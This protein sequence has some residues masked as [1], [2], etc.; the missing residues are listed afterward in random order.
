MD[1]VSPHDASTEAS[2]LTQVSTLARQFAR[3]LISASAADDLA[4][5][6]VVEC[7][8]RMRAGRW[9]VDVSLSA[10]VHALVRR[11]RADFLRQR[12][13][14]TSREAEHVR[15][16]TESTH[17]WMSPELTLEAQE[18]ERFHEQTLASLP[19]RCRQSYVMVR[20]QQAAY[21]VVATELGISRAAVCL[22]VVAAQR[23]FRE[24]LVERGF[25]TPTHSQ[26]GRRVSPT[27]SPLAP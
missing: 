14:R 9:R 6:V 15:E 24:V 17:A 2:L 26:N 25:A 23:H 8:T 1:T 20:E 21:Q 12:Q 3:Q 7:L 18:L 22:H 16:L 11:R 13:R 19:S 5:D 4:Q 10:F 27:R